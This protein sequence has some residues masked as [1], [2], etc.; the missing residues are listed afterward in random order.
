MRR[1]GAGS[2]Q[3]QV[4]GP[5]VATDVP[6]RR[7]NH[8]AAGMVATYTVERVSE[9]RDL[10]AFANRRKN[11][12]RWATACDMRHATDERLRRALAPRRRFGA[13]R[14]VPPGASATTPGPSP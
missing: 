13:N 3:R 1:F 11:F 5:T 2:F 6:Q 7:V 4:S 14:G 12:A 8:T 9:P 10:A